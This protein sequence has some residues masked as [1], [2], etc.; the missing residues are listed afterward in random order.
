MNLA[1]DFFQKNFILFCIS[2]VIFLNCIQHFRQLQKVSKYSLMIISGALLLS[3]SRL[4]EDV[5]R[6]YF[7]IPLI[8]V[9]A[10]FGY[11]IR[12]AI[13][14]LFLLMSTSYK[15]KRYWLLSSL[16]FVN[17]FIYL[18][19]F[20]P[21]VNQAV[22]R[23]DFGPVDGEVTFYG[24]PLRYTSHIVAAFYLF[25][26]LYVS[27]AQLRAKHFSQGI[28]LIACVV[29]VVLAVF[30]ETYFTQEVY[31][32]NSTIGVCCF[33]Y[34][35]YSYAEQHQFDPLTHLFNRETYYRDLKKM[36]AT[37]TAVISFD[38]N[39]LKYINDN[40]GHLEGDKALKTTG[41][42]LWACCSKNMYAYRLGGDEFIV[43]VNHDKEEDVIYAIALMKK[44]F[45]KANY[46]CSIGYSY[47]RDKGMTFIDM[48]KDSEKKMYQD[49]DEYYKTATI[50]RRKAHPTND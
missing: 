32:L 1:T 17:L 36:D 4:L 18:L 24:G 43:L 26:L 22:V 37:I 28:V 23:Y 20:I 35:L 41:E 48:V 6:K 38:L 25:Y 44:E 3:I 10:V 14:F 11:I 13:I 19:C 30:F 16:L 46:H 50:E 47:R 2:I 9:S 45:D 12:P 21:G 49:K 15:K 5:G 33:S 31:M 39:G 29:F 34:F 27:L 7:N 40:F 8:T 42:I